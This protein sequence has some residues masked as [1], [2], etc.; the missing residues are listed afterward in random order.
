MSKIKI[1][2]GHSHTPGATA[3]D[4]GTNFA[5]YSASAERVELCLFEPATYR[6]TASHDLQLTDDVW[7]GYLPGIKPGDH[8]GYRV[9]GKYDPAAGFWF[10]P[11]KLL[12]DP[13]ARELSSTVK[14]DPLHFAYANAEDPFD[15]QMDKRDNA[16]V[17][18]KCIVS[19]P[20]CAQRRPY[21][22]FDDQYK[23][24]YE[25]HV[26]GLTRQ[27]PQI[28]EN[29]RGTYRAI[30]S[31][32]LLDH[33][34]QLSITA[35]ELLPVHSFATERHLDEK[36]LSNYWGYNSVNFFTPHL[37]YACNREQAVHEFRQMAKILHDHDIELILDV[38]YNHTA[39]GNHHG[40]MLS[41]KGIDNHTYYRLDHENRFI[42]HSGCGNT[43]NFSSQPVIELVTASLRYWFECMGVDG[44]RFDLATI[45][46]R[47][48]QDK[49]DSRSCFLRILKQDP[50]LNKAKLIA[51]PW[52]VGPYGH[53]T[54]QFAAPWSQWNDHYRDTVRHYWHSDDSRLAELADSV[55]GSS[56]KFEHGSSGRRSWASVNFITSHDGYTLMDLV[57][58]V[59]K[60]NQANQENNADGHNHN[61]SNNHGVEGV[62]DD[63]E[64][65]AARDQSRR[66]L[67]ATLM[68]SQG[69]PMMLGGDEL[70]NSQNGNNNA[71]CQDNPVSWLDWQN[72][73]DQ[74][75]FLQFCRY[76]GKTRKQHSL[77]HSG[78][79]LHRRNHQLTDCRPTAS[80]L[81]M[82]ASLLSD[83]DWHDPQ[84]VSIA[85]VLSANNSPV[86]GLKG[87]KNL[88]IIFNHGQASQTFNL[89]NINSYG[90]WQKLVDTSI[91]DV[92]KMCTNLTAQ[93]N[94]AAN[95]LI[96]AAAQ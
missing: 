25:T 38:V 33:L 78:I 52:D 61:L 6:Q 19:Q 72:L 11:Y 51:E 34:S 53:Q 96:L 92:S 47:N 74:Q 41:L 14:L 73:A 66:N 3:D 29:H 71:Y 28:D 64:I 90:E 5:L 80:W 44:F 8:Y 17:V 86:S 84:L 67:F 20:V 18:P 69:V 26:K 88:L 68:L 36:G 22:G 87:A 32:V 46:G 4:R 55:L 1:L 58:Y 83:S 2:P 15:G 59:A 10:N 12:I 94:V 48:R 91:S 16:S 76:L 85:L 21:S 62:T 24:I 95:S 30:G 75:E 7:H 60:H 23:F 42:N 54:G 35:L 50:V 31:Q 81:K 56:R 65:I 77:L 37:E 89:A 13:Y 79:Y 63:P 49:F 82:D 40:P 39:E 70:G 27:H 43:L 9:H 45:L 57:S 93:I